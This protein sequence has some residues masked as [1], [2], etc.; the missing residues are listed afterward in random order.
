M[1]LVKI[2]DLGLVCH[3]LY[4]K[5]MRKKYALQFQAYKEEQREK[6]RENNEYDEYQ[7]EFTIER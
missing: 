3:D 4:K 2:V 7:R 1:W 6:E 5:E